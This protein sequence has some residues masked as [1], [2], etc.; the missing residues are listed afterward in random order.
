MIYSAKLINGLE[1]LYL[2]KRRTSAH[3]WNYASE[4]G[5]P[6]LRFLTLARLKPELKTLASLERQRI[7]EEGNLQ[8]KAVVGDIREAG[9]DLDETHSSFRWPEFELSGAIDGFVKIDG[10]KVPIEIKSASPWSFET[11]KRL[12]PEEMMQSDQLFI[13]KYITQIGLYLLMTNSP[14]GILFFKDK[15]SGAPHAVDVELE[16]MLGFLDGVLKNLEAVNGFVKKGEI[17]PACY[18]GDIC[19]KCDFFQTGC[20]IEQDFGQGLEVISDAEIESKIREAKALEPSSKRYDE[21]MSEIKD[22]AKAKGRDSLVGDY[23]VKVKTYETTRYDIPAEIK[24]S[25]A[26]KTEAVRVTLERLG[27]DDES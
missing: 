2:S 5:H 24:K 22:W 23:L 4:A 12:T 21:L 13:R 18:N 17:P 1:K 16:P 19:P 11:Y 8:E 14:V 20:L 9:F 6:C 10:A 26:V 3:V 25:Y 7:Y 27:G 15:V